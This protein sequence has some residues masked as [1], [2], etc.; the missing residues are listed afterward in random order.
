M[1][2][3]GSTFTP[4]DSRLTAPPTKASQ[5][6]AFTMTTLTT[7]P[8]WSYDKTIMDLSKAK[9]WTLVDA[10]AHLSEIVDRALE[11]HPQVISRRGDPPIVVIA[12]HAIAQA[13]DNTSILDLLQSCP[14]PF[15]IPARSTRKRKPLNL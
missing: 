4:A 3:G 9:T 10:K 5:E 1:V 8:S 12:Q 11:G 15:T 6:P 13:T 7:R 14:A 2:W